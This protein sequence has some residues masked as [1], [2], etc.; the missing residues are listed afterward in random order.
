VDSRRFVISQ[1]RDREGTPGSNCVAW[2]GGVPDLTEPRKTALAELHQ[3]CGA[4]M[5]DFA[6][7]LMPVQ[8]PAGII[9][10]HTHCRTSAALFDVSH[11][12]QIAVRGHRAASLFEAIV[13]GD[14]TSLTPSRARYTMLTNTAGGVIDDLIV[15]RTE[16]GLFVVV[17]ASRRDIDV[18]IIRAALGEECVVCELTDHSLLALQGPRAAAVLTRLS[19]GIADLRFMQSQVFSIAGLECRISRLGYTGE[20]GFEIS[21]NSDYA[22]KL[23]R[24]LLA[25]EQVEWAGLGARDS[26]RLEAGL[27]LYGHELDEERTPIDAGLAWTISN[28]R[29]QLGGFPGYQRIRAHLRDGSPCRLVGIVPDGRAPA[30]AGTIVEDEGGTPIGKITSGGFGPTVSAPVAMGYVDAAH[31][32]PGTALRLIVRGKP[33]SATIRALP[34]VPH[35]YHR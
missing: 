35:R 20:D 18:P 9:R 29:R 19:A 13:P 31:S 4:R 11:M 30:R 22:R 17:N 15:T 3:E 23:A 12:G 5:V 14:I 6:G 1:V 27:C 2:N 16:D 34:F 10:E 8:Y 25:D 28:R 32:E 26:L 24:T 33:I 21:V 7:W